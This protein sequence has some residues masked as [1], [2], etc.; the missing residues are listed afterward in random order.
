[1]KV[2]K[3]LTREEL[4]DLIWATPMTKL[5]KEFGL[6]GNGLKKKCL[7][8]EIPRPPMGY[9]EKIKH[10]KPVRKPPLPKI[11]DPSLDTIEFYPKPEHTYEVALPAK[12][13]EDPIHIKAAGFKFPKK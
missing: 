4:Y 13:N 1:M 5:A 3:E 9:W 8:H 11:N 10:G 12:D 7:K 6:S 2:L